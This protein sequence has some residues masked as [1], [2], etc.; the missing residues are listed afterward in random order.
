MVW[1]THQYK[2]NLVI[3]LFLFK[4]SKKNL[5]LIQINN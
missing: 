2:E 4:S 5:L 3:Y 1:E